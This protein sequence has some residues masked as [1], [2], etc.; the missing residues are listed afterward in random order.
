M[1]EEG[2]GCI[3]ILGG[4][5]H[6]TGQESETGGR[7]HSL[8]AR[9]EKLFPGAEITHRWSGQVIETVD[10]LPFIGATSDNQF[11]ATG[12]SGDGMTF[13]TVAAMMVRDWICGDKSPW[14]RLLSP[15]RRTISSA[16]EYVRENVDFPIRMITDRLQVE[17][18]DPETIA[19][20]SAAVFKFHGKRVAAFRSPEG[21]LHVCSA[22]CP[23]LGCIVAWNP[24]EQT[25]DC[26]CHGSRFRPDGKV[27][28][29]PAEA[30]L[31]AMEG[32]SS[33]GT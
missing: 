9:L 4:G 8:E 7:Y 12:F 24:A 21:K 29:G 22:I 17:K 32:F 13:G 14:S 3:C 31:Q 20:G 1:Q 26:P 15:S 19:P 6:R 33:S 28:A 18:G 30:G 16:L 25:W 10:G 2:D 5:D 11:I 23:H 27:I